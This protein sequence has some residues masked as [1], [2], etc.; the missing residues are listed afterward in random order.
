MRQL[1]RTEIIVGVFLMG[2]LALAAFAAFGP[3]NSAWFV[4]G[5]FAGATLVA[6]VLVTLGGNLV[7]RRR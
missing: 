6:D 1:S 7:R 3:H 2:G 4:V 5:V